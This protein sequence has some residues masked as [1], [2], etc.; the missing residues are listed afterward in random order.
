LDLLKRYTTLFAIRHLIDG[1][2]DPRLSRPS[3]A[4]MELSENHLARI[5]SDWFIVE[6]H[7]ENNNDDESE[8]LLLILCYLSLY[9]N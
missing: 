2:I 4:F 6:E 1:G 3:N 8:G 5:M 7:L 9:I